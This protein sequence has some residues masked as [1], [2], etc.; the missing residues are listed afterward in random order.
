MSE[1]KPTS[2]VRRLIAVFGVI[3]L[4]AA[5]PGGLAGCAKKST[6]QSAHGRGAG[7]GQPPAI[8]VSAAAVRRGN[9]SS[10]FSLTG[11]VSPAQQ[12][13][14]A[15]VISGPVQSV[16]VQIGDRVA[17]GQLLVKI[18][19]STLRAQ[20]QQ[21]EA[22]LA[23]ARARLAQTQANDVGASATSN[24]SLESARVA[25]EN[26]ASNLRR[27]QQL[28]A[29]GYVSASAIDQAQQQA[30]AAQSQLRAAQVTAQN[31][32]LGG[33]SGTAAQADIRNAQATVAQA[34]AGINYLS[35][36]IAQTSVVAPFSGV[37]TQRSVDPGSLAAPATTLVQVSQL[38]PC[39]VNVG[40]PDTD[41]Q[42]VRGGTGA[43]I[44][45]DSLPGRKW[46]GKVTNLNAAT[47]QG[48]LSYLARISIPNRDLSLKGGMVANVVFPQATRRGVLLV[49][50]GA[51]VQ[52]DNG[53]AVYVVASGK[54]K[55]IPVKLGVQ[56]DN[57][58][59]LSGP[60]IRVGMLAITAR[61]DSLQD[62]SPVSVVGAKGGARLSSS[63]TSR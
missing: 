42:F 14:L 17:A 1:K 38:D 22:A 28:F 52:T 60:G 3:A 40:I 10:R 18:D 13:N 8:P 62:G 59:E 25:Y 9:I 51:I 53:A 36:Q 32:N 45:V 33:S 61:P 16:T 47:A 5:A 6:S 29:Q 4:L 19:D 43:A 37:V 31:A 26:A 39:F 46:Q 21:D 48:T 50:R 12:A 15:S 44:S 24:A 34:Q 57:D 23:S 54:A 2:I 20:L 30:A 27:N 11:T 35:A 7:S 63:Q 49:P 41:L 55:M 56:T 58:A